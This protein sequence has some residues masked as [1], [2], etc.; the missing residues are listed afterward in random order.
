MDGQDGQDG[1]PGFDGNSARYDII[2]IGSTPGN[3]RLSF[4]PNGITDWSQVTIILV[5][6]DDIN[7]TGNGDLASWILNAEVGA[8]VTVRRVY[9][10]DGVNH[11]EGGY[12][13]V[14]QP[15]L[16][17]EVLDKEHIKYLFNTFRRSDL[18][19]KSSFSCQMAQRRYSII[20]DT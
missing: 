1:V 3:G 4:G 2:P 17:L 16:L 13:K 9:G 15:G 18:M 19:H 10:Q 12:Y 5:S 14:T 8:F 11:Y 20:M 7:G 6:D